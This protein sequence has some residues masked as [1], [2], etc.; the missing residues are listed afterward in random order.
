MS[1]PSSKMRMEPASTWTSRTRRRVVSGTLY[2][3]PPTQTM[4]SCDAAFEPEH[5]LIRYKRERSQRA[6]FLGEGLVDDPAGSCMHPRIGDRVQPLLQLD[7]EVFEIPERTGEE[8][9]FANVAERP[10]DF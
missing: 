5:R 9:V 7:V 8:E 3:L 4:P 6:A 10:F 1:A 2:K